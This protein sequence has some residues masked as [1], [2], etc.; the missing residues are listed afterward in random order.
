MPNANLY[1]D[2]TKRIL[3]MA[4]G[5]SAASH[6]YWRE[7]D[8]H[9]LQDIKNCKGP[10]VLLPNGETIA[11]TKKGRLPLSDNLSNEAT[12]AMIL[13]GLESASLISIG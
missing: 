13:P 12:T 5:D 8:D 9:V 4:K 10:A 11:S 1:P 6:H 7:Q 3:V 2:K